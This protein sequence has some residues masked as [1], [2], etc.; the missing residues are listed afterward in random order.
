MLDLAEL[1]PW[2]NVALFAAA[3]VVIWIAGTK[4]A[5]L[6]DTIATVTGLG[7]AIVGILLL[8]G[9]T[10]LP[11]I[12]V[13][14]TATLQG[15]PALTINDV[16]GSAAINVVILAVADAVNGRRALTAIQDSPVLM[17]QGV[18]GML[19]LACAAAPAITGERLVAGIGA[20]SWIMLATYL[21]AI[22]IIAK[23]NTDRAWLAAGKDQ[24]AQ[25][26]EGNT[27]GESLQTLVVKTTAAGAAILVA[28]FVL[29]RTGEGLA[30]QSGLGTSFFGAIFLA[31]ATSL[32]EWSTV[33]A[34]TRLR[35]YDMAISDIFGTNLFNV[36]IIVLVDALHPGGPVMLEAG[37]FAAFGAIL[38]L[39]LTSFFVIGMLERRDRTVLHLGWDSVAVLLAYV[40]GVFVLH[41]LR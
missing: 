2:M 18:L 15:T 39:A 4:L 33:I 20:W 6:A 19:L 25:D 27:S 8:G 36:T 1:S 29:A 5:R 11:E 40:A 37:N 21:A 7:R 31:F 10:S 14:T 12:A 16:L 17:L 34:A 24:H 41:G 22:R 13:A 28:G 23:S 38:A 30:E 26:D 3:A 9:V 35:R 32:P